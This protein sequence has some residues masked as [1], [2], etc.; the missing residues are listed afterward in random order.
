[1]KLKQYLEALQGRWSIS[2]IGWCVLTPVSLFAYY[3]RGRIF[4]ELSIIG[5][6]IFSLYINIFTTFLFYIFSQTILRKRYT[7]QQNLLK[8]FLVFFSIWGLNSIN[9]ILLTKFL[10]NKPQHIYTE[11]IASLI[12]TVSGLILTNMAIGLLAEGLKNQKLLKQQLADLAIQNHQ[13]SENLSSEKLRLKD[14]IERL[15]LDQL[16]VIKLSVENL[17]SKSTKIQLGEIAFQIENYAT[18]VVREL[19]HSLAQKPAINPTRVDKSFHVSSQSRGF[20]PFISTKFFLATELVA[21]GFLQAY[22]NG[23]QGFWL[24][25]GLSFSAFLLAIFGAA[26]LNKIKTN[27]FKYGFTVFYVLI[28]FVALDQLLIFFQ[29]VLANLEFP[30]STS[31][32]SL[33][34]TL[35]FILTSGFISALKWLDILNANLE[36]IREINLADIEAKEQEILETRLQVS[37]ALHGSI[38]GR[39][40]GIAMALRFVEETDRSD[41]ENLLE[42]EEKILPQFNLIATDLV[43]ILNGEK[44]QKFGTSLEKNLLGLKEDWTNLVEIDWKLPNRLSEPQRI[45]FIEDMMLVCNEAIS[46]AVRHGQASQVSIDFTHHAHEV[47]LKIRN[48][49]KASATNYEKGLG[50]DSVSRISNHYRLENLPAGGTELTVSFD[51]QEY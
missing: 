14:T 39:L 12:P 42:I 38:Q 8:V 48:N 47:V 23:L 45:E 43:R 50:L 17:N 40:A 35:A 25:I 2:L 36:K 29:D 41:G 22:R 24:Q 34:F 33:R 30:F 6:W 10:L 51:A 28:F 11:I 46:N 7:Q 9:E 27:K 1:V 4:L 13:S 18:G 26:V 5:A 31:E 15:L 32:L 3:I 19:A 49:G 20:T 21:G 16:Q 37:S 44:R